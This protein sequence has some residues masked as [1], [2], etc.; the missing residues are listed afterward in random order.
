M[1]HPTCGNTAA[2]PCTDAPID[3][4]LFLKRTALAALGMAVASLTKQAFAAKASD[5]TLAALDAA[6]ASYDSAMATLSDLGTQLEAAQWQLSQ[7]QAELEATNAQIVELEAT[8]A[9]RQIELQ[10]AQDVLANRIK[11]NYTSGGTEMLDVLFSATSFEDFVS[12]L[13]YAGKVNDADAAA[14]QNVKD[15]KA[16]LEAEEAAL[17]EQRVYQEQLVAEQQAA[18]DEL[19]AWVA[20]YEEYTA[21]LS[22]EVQALMAQAQAELEAAQQAEYEEYLRQQAAANQGSSGGSSSGGDYTGGGAG[23]SVGGNGNHVYAVSDIA[24]NYIGIPYVWGGTTTSGFD[25]SGLT[26]YCYAMAGYSIGR[27]TWDQMANISARGQMVYSMSELQP[28][29]LVFPHDGHVGIYMGGGMMIHAPYP[30]EYVKYAS[31]YAFSFGGC[32]V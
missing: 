31:V 10:E 11:A 9:Q 22:Y 8:I 24:W 29:D 17:Q 19:N 15:I 20:Y 4:R 2:S 18:T 30:G 25:C 26:Q 13:Y 32:P 3:R 21:N 1:T 16:Q 7:L 23:S 14:I 28:G 5:E 27:T 12:R 6:Q